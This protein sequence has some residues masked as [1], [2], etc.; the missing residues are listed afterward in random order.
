[1]FKIGK[2]NKNKAVI[3]YF[4]TLKT[5]QDFGCFCRYFTYKDL[6]SLYSAEMLQNL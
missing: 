1:M 6:Y 3:I 5:N 2:K 4:K